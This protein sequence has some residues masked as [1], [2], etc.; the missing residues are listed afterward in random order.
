MG[1]DDSFGLFPWADG[2]SGTFLL[3]HLSFLT[4]LLLMLKDRCVWLRYLHFPQFYLPDL[5]RL[6]L[7]PNGVS[8]LLFY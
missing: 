4:N 7:I 1:D 6:C 5:V 3:L 8:P 2:D